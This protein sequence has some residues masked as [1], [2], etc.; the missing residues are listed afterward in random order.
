MVVVGAIL[1]VGC[2]GGSP[3]PDG[4]PR[5][6]RGSSD[7]ITEAEISA[8]VYQNALEII[9]N[10][11]PGMLVARGTGTDFVP[12][13]AYMDDVRLT[14]LNGLATIPSNRIQEIRFMNARDATT[15][16]GTG[17]GS[18]VIQVTTKRN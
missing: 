16:Y 14:E 17:H 11:R 6:V 9:Q 18:G 7:R 3:S 15:R 4:A 5:P 8:G 1:L 13:V 10:L 2:G 12:V